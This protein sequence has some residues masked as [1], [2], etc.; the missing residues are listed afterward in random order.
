MDT[1]KITDKGRTQMIA[2]RGLSGIERENTVNAF[3]AACNHSYFGVECDIHVTADN[4]YL[5]YHDDRTGRLCDRDLAM[6]ESTFDT[7]RGLRIRES[8]G[9]DFDALLKMPTLEE[10]LQVIARCEKTAVIELKNPMKR[11]NIR[12]AVEICKK[13][14]NLDNIIFISFVF[15]N[16]TVLRE[17]LPQSRLQFLTGEWTEDLPEK[18]REHR[19]DVDI[20]YWALTEENIKRFHG[21]GIAVNCWTCDDPEAAGQLIAWGVDYI[22]TNILE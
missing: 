17:I 21:S 20:G 6:E 13:H 12:A 2:H 19:L 22:T 8:G 3:V 4:R 9:E 18:L 10:Y 1:I 14:Y 16:L 11:E 15:E 5:V 7:L